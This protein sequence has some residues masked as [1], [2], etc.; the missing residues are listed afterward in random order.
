MTLMVVANN[1][2]EQSVFFRRILREGGGGRR[3]NANIASLTSL[4]IAARQSAFVSHTYGNQNTENCE[5]VS[6]KSKEQKYNG[7]R[8]RE[9][10]LTVM[11]SVASRRRQARARDDI[12]IIMRIATLF[13]ADERHLP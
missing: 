12:N 6:V 8:A 4:K 10:N 3:I 1:G 2:T 11:Y 5:A 9:K 13:P 7:K